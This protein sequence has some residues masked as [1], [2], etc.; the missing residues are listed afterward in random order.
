MRQDTPALRL[1]RGLMWLYPA[2][3]R[4][5]FACDMCRTLADCL[6]ERPG[7]VAILPLYL[8]I[9]LDAP[10]ERYY[11]IRQ[12]VIY[13]LRTMRREKLT[14][15]VAT[16]VLAIG[17]GST[18]TV[19][20]LV[21]GLLLR[22][23]P[24][25]SQERIVYVEEISDDFH[26]VIAYPN[27]LDFQSRNR[28]LAD[29]AMFGSGPTTLRGDIAAERVPAASVGEP[30]FR[31]LGV[32]PL[33][34]RT[35]TSEENR[36][37]APQTV[38]LGEELWRRRYGADAGILGKTIGVDSEQARVIGIM[39]SSFHFPDVAQ[40]WRPLQLDPAHNTRMDHGLE[41]IARLRPG[42]TVAQ[43][44]D[45]LR[46]IMRQIIGEHP[47][48]NY[49]QTVKVSPYRER[50]IQG[51]KP[52]LFTLLGA[53]GFVL[54][55]ACAN[56][57]NLLLVKASGRT[58]EIALRGA[59]GASQA[60]LVRQFI[61]ESVI[62]GIGGAATGVMLAW[63]AVPALR[64]LIPEQI[65]SWIKFTPDARVLLFAIAVTVGT[66]ILAGAVPA[67]LAT[68]LNLVETLKE[69]GRSYTSG[70]ARAWF[71][72]ALVVGEVAM[73]VL[74][75]AGAGLMIETFWNLSHMQAG[76]RTDNITTLQTSTPASRYPIGSP[77]AQLVRRIRN[78][79]QSLP[80]V[81]SVAGASGVPLIDGWGRSIT[82]EGW[83]VLSLKDAPMVNHT[84][85][86]PGYFRTLGIAIRQGRDFTESD[87]KDPLVT[88]VDE[89]LAKR[90]WPGQSAI[91][92]RV[93]FGPPEWNEPW[94]LIVGVAGVARNG[95]L[96]DIGNS[97][98]LP[99]GE[100]EYSSI[101]Y[102]VRTAGGMA[103]AA[104]A[105]HARLSTIDRNIAISRVMTMRDVV[106]RSIWR[107][108]FFATIFGVF[109]ILALL[110]ALVGLYGVMAYTV[111]RRSH[112]IG[113]R[114]ALGAST[115]EIRGM[116]LAHSGRLVSLGLVIG[117]VAAVYLTRLLA[118]QLYGVHA[119]DP[120]TLGVVAALLAT[121]ALLASY[122]PARRATRVDPMVALREE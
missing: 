120:R 62:L 18:V 111:S 35:F 17:I 53:V 57:T 90:Y 87:A 42:T 24:Y 20:T 73:S 110:L 89:N 76:F 25:P 34:G 4:D 12:D 69:G 70:G 8:G 23:L 55:I 28:T 44:Q 99:Y 114:M 63:A 92:K 49:G 47:G 109:A 88:I 116:V 74:L 113:I 45:D 1:Y 67:W 84:V 33:L 77:A 91:G 68:R 27:Y 118:A 78:E 30:L 14:T 54:L 50:D 121:A 81:I 61:V 59:L 58:R 38:I 16:L 122:L 112:E 115:G 31:I 48:E 10:K 104:K 3:F 5:H 66:S 117:T 29:I 64:V 56:I 71:R 7:T 105:L 95:S 100:F 101:A 11:M 83:P 41:G 26:G 19:F 85:V 107:E 86:T 94:H 37:D 82:A 102:L 2:E 108:R 60:R 80:G 43:G 103:D 97:V 72:N 32:Q 93:R 40:L 52:L 22:S 9:L 65:P 51:V 106:T 75:L 15:L 79:L 98:Y 6:R 46:R 96:R 39:P 36:P 13:A 21:N 119:R